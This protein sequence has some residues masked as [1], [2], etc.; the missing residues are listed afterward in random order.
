MR[1]AQYVADDAAMREERRAEAEGRPRAFDL[2]FFQMTHLGRLPNAEER[3]VIVR[4]RERERVLE[5][6]RV[7]AAFTKMILGEAAKKKEV[8]ILEMKALYVQLAREREAKERV[9]WEGRGGGPLERLKA[10]LEE[11]WVVLEGEVHN[12]HYTHNYTYPA[13][14]LE[15]VK[16]HTLARSHAASE[17][18]DTAANSLNTPPLT[19][20]DSERK[21]I[22][23][24]LRTAAKRG[25]E[26]AELGCLSREEQGRAMI[27]VVREG[28]LAVG[29]DAEIGEV[30]SWGAVGLEDAVEVGM[31]GFRKGMKG[32][33]ER[34]RGV[35][36]VEK[37]EAGAEKKERKESAAEEWARRG[38]ERKMERESERKMERARR[39]LTEPPNIYK[40]ES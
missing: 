15:S 37:R 40:A 2:Q 5:E 23:R 25:S 21:D 12:V 22:K 31:R 29:V 38:R 9:R 39:L 20:T 18:A 14:I 3:V 13:D 10:R 26:E 17:A 11:G 36:A 28:L 27:E 34:V 8:A 19:F 35:E 1:Q 30:K 4:E 33:E 7:E 32:I 24:V 16:S 6:A